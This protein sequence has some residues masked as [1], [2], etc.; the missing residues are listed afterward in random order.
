MRRDGDTEAHPDA[1]RGRGALTNTSGRFESEA[2][3]AIDDGWGSLDAEPAPIRTT[4]AIDTT[5]TIIARNKSPDVP[6]DRSI[7]PYRGCEHGCIYCFARPTHAF[8]GLSPGLDFESRLFVKP[9]AAKL[10]RQELAKPGYRPAVMALGT[11][12]D[13]YQPIE[14]EHRVTRSVLE[15][16]AECNHPLAITT[17]SNLVVRDLDILAPMAKRGLAKVCVSVTT[18]DRGLARAMEPRAP[19]PTRRL[20]AIA[21]LSAAGVPTAISCSPMI[22]GLTDHEMEALLAAGARHGAAEAGCIPVRLPLEI[23]DLFKQWLASTVPDRAKRVIS[24]VKAMRGGK[25]YDSTWGKRMSGEGPMADLLRRRFDIAC[26]R[27]GLN[28]RH[29][30]FDLTHFRRPLIG[31]DDRQL[32]L[33]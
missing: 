24:L 21:A 17:K 6:F 30:E 10:L 15:V 8:L 16:L 11:N 27:L 9:D 23:E 3:V 4:I 31:R 1:R 14:R 33:L 29:H 22:P 7:N 25:V 5:K 12:T 13:P 18:L 19:T 28:R 32:S 20:E 26:A 2:R